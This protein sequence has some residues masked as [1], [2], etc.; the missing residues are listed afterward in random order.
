MEIY[1]STK[2]PTHLLQCEVADGMFSN[3]RSVTVTDILGK[4]AST[5]IPAEFV[6]DSEK[7]LKLELSPL[8]IKDNSDHV[9]IIA[10]TT[11]W[12]ESG[13]R[14]LEIPKRNVIPTPLL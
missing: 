2:K 14:L 8:S 4:K 10:P 7:C 5:F 13:R 12:L 1:Q 9:F 11:E 3:E 6:D